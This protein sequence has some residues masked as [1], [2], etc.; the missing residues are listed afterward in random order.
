MIER[1]YDILYI[2]D[3]DGNFTFL[4]RSLSNLL[5]YTPEELVGRNFK[6]I[7]SSESYESAE[8]IF[9]KYRKG[10]KVG[11]YELELIDKGGRKKTIE[12]LESIVWD[13]ESIV[14]VHG[15]GRDITERKLAEKTLVGSEKRF[16]ELLENATDFVYQVD[17]EGK[18][19][20]INRALREFSGYIIEEISNRSI[21]EFMA[22]QSKKYA[23]EIVRRQV[24]GE[25]VGAFELDMLCKDGSVI[26]VEVQENL[27]WENGRIIEVYGIARDV[28]HRKHAEERLRKIVR[29]Q[30]TVLNSVSEGVAYY[31]METRVIWANRAFCEI[32]GADIEELAGKHCYKVWFGRDAPCNGCP[33]L[34]TIRTGMSNE[35][36][37][38]G[39]EKTWFVRVYPVLDLKGTITGVSVVR[40]DIKG[41]KYTQDIIKK[42]FIY[43]HPIS[44]SDDVPFHA[45]LDPDYIYPFSLKIDYQGGRFVITLGWDE[46]KRKVSLERLTRSETLCARFIYL[47]AKMKSDGTGWVDKKVLRTGP[48]DANLN[49]LRNSLEE[50]AIPF[51]DRFSAR[52]MIRSSRDEKGKVRLALSPSNIEI[53]ENIKGI[54]S[55]KYRY[56]DNTDK[57]IVNIKGKI[58]DSNENI[59]LKEELCVQMTNRENILKSI[60]TVESLMDASIRLLH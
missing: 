29:G 7:L 44:D 55:K 2:V 34:E 50:S 46:L 59:Y 30:E 54:C 8:E 24:V 38:G 18:I 43:D 19:I 58:A 60:E 53:S 11:S 49:K 16:R 5:G 39:N 31:D 42:L 51:L 17:G 57:K 32:A 52:M 1:I 28:T 41:E 22:P 36:E 48:M 35:G 4:N 15:I 25:D 27:K 26:T 12:T 21:I 13:G 40:T 23:E 3:S 37:I 33:V 10:E 9:K 14:E 45:S 47:A 6:E 20:F 56:L